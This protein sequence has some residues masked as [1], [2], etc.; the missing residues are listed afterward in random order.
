MK[1]YRLKLKGYPLYFRSTT[2]YGGARLSL[3]GRIYTTRPQ[4]GWGE[5][6][7]CV[8]DKGIQEYFPGEW[9]V[10]F[11]KEDWEVVACRITDE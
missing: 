10:E 6:S 3:I 7:F 1:A 8:N 5:K 9:H 4:L 2:G 11:K